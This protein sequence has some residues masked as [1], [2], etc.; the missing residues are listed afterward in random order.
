MEERT[1]TGKWECWFINLSFLVGV[2]HPPP[3]PSREGPN[4][5]H[6]LHQDVE[7]FVRVVT[8][9]ESDVVTGFCRPRMLGEDT[10]DGIK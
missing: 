6:A 5:R 9:L 10:T 3:T 4:D 1:Q 7:N 8:S 2:D